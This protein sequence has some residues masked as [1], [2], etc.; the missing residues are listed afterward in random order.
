MTCFYSL[1]TAELFLGPTRWPVIDS[2]AVQHD[3]RPRAL[4]TF[5]MNYKGREMRHYTVCI[6]E[7]TECVD[8]CGKHARFRSFMFFRTK[9]AKRFH[10]RYNRSKP[11]EHILNK[12]TK[13]S[14]MCSLNGKQR[15]TTNKNSKVIHA[16][17]G[18]WCKRS[19]NVNAPVIQVVVILRLWQPS[20]HQSQ[21]CVSR[22]E[23]TSINLEPDVIVWVFCPLH[24]AR[25]QTS[26]LFAECKSELGRVAL[27]P[28]LGSRLWRKVLN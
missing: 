10:S 28:V 25:K 17:E 19:L 8:V 23:P 4:F 15:W 24:Y 26:W 11:K 13:S 5:H 18:G 9:S 27:R 21:P 1:P 12:S 22:G 14:V 2:H 16:V 6:Q 7:H 20:M 3:D